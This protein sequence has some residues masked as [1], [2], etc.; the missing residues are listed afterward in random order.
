MKTAFSGGFVGFVL[1]S[2]SAGREKS[3]RV[4]AG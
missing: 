3:P 4:R 2:G 1:F